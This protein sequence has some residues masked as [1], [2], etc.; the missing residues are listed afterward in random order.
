M[1]N[2]QFN[3]SGVPLIGYGTRGVFLTTMGAP[4]FKPKKLSTPQNDDPDKTSVQNY[5]IADWGAGNNFPAFAD[6]II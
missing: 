3:K 1:S 2:V 6:K 4:E 5:D